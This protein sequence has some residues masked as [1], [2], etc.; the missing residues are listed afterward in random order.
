MVLPVPGGCLLLPPAVAAWLPAA[1]C[2][3][4]LLLLPAG[5]WYELLP[6]GL[7]FSIFVLL[8]VDLLPLF[9]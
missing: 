8:I 7:G 5:D 9:L 2:C 4:R 1:A 3:C 6:A